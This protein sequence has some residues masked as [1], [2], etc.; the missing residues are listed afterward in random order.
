MSFLATESPPTPADEPAVGNDGWF[1]DID[2]QRLREE[3]RLDG[4]VTA[5][6]LRRALLVSMSSVNAELADYRARQL[7]QG[8]ARL[9]AVP[10]S[11]LGGEHLTQVL[12]LRA[13]HAAVQAEL[14]EVYRDMDTAAQSG[15]A[16]AAQMEQQR[17]ALKVD[18]HRRNLRWAISDLLGLRRTTVE[19]I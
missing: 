5:P 8:H 9:L 17:L 15:G 18:E 12:Y 13:I 11:Q 19:L 2:L 3:C 6:R 16:Q 14:T 4:S 10:S 1:P 7:A